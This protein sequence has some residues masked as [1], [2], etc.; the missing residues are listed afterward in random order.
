[1]SDSPLHPAA[2]PAASTAPAPGAQRTA[3]LLFAPP[4]ALMGLRWLL[5][6]QHDRGPQTPVLA[7]T[8]FAPPQDALG[9]LWPL[10]C[11]VLALVV[12]VLG[13]RWAGRRWGWRAVQRFW[14]LAW[15]ALCVAG[16][17]ALLWGH[18][19]V[20]GVQRLAPVS[21][22]VLGSRFTPPSQ[23]GTG[24]TLL[25]LRVDGLDPTQQVLIDDPQAAQWR[26]GQRVLLQ[27]ARGRSSGLF[28]TGWQALPAPAAPLP[29]PAPADAAHSGALAQ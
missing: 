19:N 4:A 26:P 2:A 20:Q 17:A 10:L 9:A 14:L 12:G 23:R 3:W 28:V 21:A 8:P 15:V 18:L 1:M 24:G 11:A 25:V 6:W 29:L 22:Q 27:W 16:G 13:T 7:L 5:E